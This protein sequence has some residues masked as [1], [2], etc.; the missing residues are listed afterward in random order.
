MITS[1]CLQKTINRR[2]SYDSFQTF[3]SFQLQE[4]PDSVIF[5]SVLVIFRSLL[6]Q[7]LFFLPLNHHCGEHNGSY[8]TFQFTTTCLI[9]YMRRSL[10]QR[11]WFSTT[12][13]HHICETQILLYIPVEATISCGSLQVHPLP[14]N[15]LGIWQVSRRVVHWF[16]LGRP[17]SGTTAVVWPQRSELLRT[18]IC[19]AW[20]LSGLT[21]PDVSHPSHSAL[22]PYIE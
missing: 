6:F 7:V 15:A 12:F 9:A 22:V 14:R 8:E 13:T 20:H 19:R 3:D 21:S 16:L 17:C 2:D 1:K 18:T 5:F 10:Q 4:F 11:G